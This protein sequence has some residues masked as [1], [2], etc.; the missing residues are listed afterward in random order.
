MT[1][2]IDSKSGVSPFNPAIGM[3][4][5]EGTYGLKLLLEEA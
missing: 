4:L 1:S 5:G 3:V 2:K